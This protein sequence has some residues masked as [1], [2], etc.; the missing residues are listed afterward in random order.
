MRLK[1]IL[2]SLV[3]GATVCGN[4]FA[5]YWSGYKAYSNE[6]YKTAKKEWVASANAGEAESQNG[7]GMLYLYGL[8][9]LKS[10]KKAMEWFKKSSQQG[11]GWAAQS[12]GVMYATGKGVTKSMRQA[13]YWMELAAERDIDLAKYRIGLMYAKGEGVKESETKAEYWLGLAYDSEDEDISLRAASVWNNYL[14]GFYKDELTIKLGFHEIHIRLD[15]G[16]WN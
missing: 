5:D 4:S 11:N 15:T 7:L 1:A 10:H 2:F 6:D 16:A 9:T 14:S 13:S 3:I 8:G 12:I